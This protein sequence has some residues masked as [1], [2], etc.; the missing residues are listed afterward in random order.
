MKEALICPPEP[1]YDYEGNVIGWRVADILPEGQTW[2]PA[3]P[4]FWSPC[5]DDTVPEL[6]YWDTTTSQI[7]PKPVP[8][9]PADQGI[10]TGTQTV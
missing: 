4:Y 10:S 7:L 3:D 6:V 8:P 2:P 1:A 9:I 5:A